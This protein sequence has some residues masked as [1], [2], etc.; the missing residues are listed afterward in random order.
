MYE[1]AKG[2][3]VRVDLAVQLHDDIAKDN[4]DDSAHVHRLQP[5]RQ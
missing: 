3:Q 2:H 4:E 5:R 1:Q